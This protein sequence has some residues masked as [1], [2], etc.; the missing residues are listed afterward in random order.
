MMTHEA[1][2][3]FLFQAQEWSHRHMWDVRISDKRCFMD[4]PISVSLWLF[5]T[6]TIFLCLIQKL[7]AE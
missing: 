5:D 2:V 4:L 3:I 1:P 6:K 7:F